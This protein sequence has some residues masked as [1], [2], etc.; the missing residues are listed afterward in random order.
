MRFYAPGL[1]V[2]RGH[3]VFGSSVRQRFRP[4]SPVR[5]RGFSR[6]CGLR[7]LNVYLK[8]T[9]WGGFSELPYKNVYAVGCPAVGPISSACTSMCRHI[10]DWNIVECDVKQP[11]SLNSVPFTK[12]NIKS[13]GGQAVIKLALWVHLMVPHTSLTYHAPGERAGSKWRT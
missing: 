10:F 12:C 8:A 1:K 5:T 11:I 4:A 3:L 6:E 2:S 13:L 9:K 7:I